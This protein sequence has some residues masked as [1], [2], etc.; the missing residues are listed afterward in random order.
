LCSAGCGGN[1][2]QHC[3]QNQKHNEEESMG[4]PIERFV[5]GNCFG[6]E[7]SRLERFS[8]MRTGCRASEAK[9]TTAETSCNTHFAYLFLVSGR[10]FM[11]IALDESFQDW[12][13]VKG[14]TTVHFQHS[15]D[16][17]LIG[18]K[19]RRRSIIARTTLTLKSCLAESPENG[20]HERCLA[21]QAATS[22]EYR[23]TV[24]PHTITDC[25]ELR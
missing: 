23:G 17:R 4:L 5:F 21:A 25:F 13:T 14:G 7:G 6:V 15:A 22:S 12:G 1:E 16:N 2:K 10:G 19:R 18:E 9:T 8:A 3:R 24:I 11:L 20:A